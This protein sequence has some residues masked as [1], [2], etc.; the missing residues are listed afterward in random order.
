MP[1]YLEHDH[2]EIMIP[3]HITRIGL[4]TCQMTLINAIITYYNGYY[5]LGLLDFCLYLT[6]LAHWRKIKHSGIERKLDIAFVVI[7]LANA[8]YESILM[9]QIY[10][11]IWIVSLLCGCSLFFINEKLFY[12]QVLHKGCNISEPFHYFSLAYTKPGTLERELA[13][14]RNVITHGI[15]LH[16]GLNLVSIYCIVHNPLYLNNYL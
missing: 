12:Y 7:T 14:Y 3:M 13:Y 9:N 8:T 4:F 1:K 16:V 2:H 6:S 5:L 15:S 11:C 10:T